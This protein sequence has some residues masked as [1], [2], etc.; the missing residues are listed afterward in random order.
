M[1]TETHTV[2][3][4]YPGHAAENDY[5]LIESALGGM[6]ATGQA[7]EEASVATVRLP[8][9][10]TDIDSDEHTVEAMRAVG[11]A[12][13]LAQG[14]RRAAAL[15]ADAVMWACTSGSFLYGWAGAH[16]QA[17]ALAQ[18]C[19][20]PASSTSLAFAAACAHLG[21][22][23]V[24]VVASYPPEVAAG[25][26]DFLG[27]AGITVAAWRSHHIETATEAG[28]LDGD[29][30]FAMVRAGVRPDAD[31]ILVPDTALHTAAWLA[32]LETDCGIP[33]LTANQVTVWQ[34]LRLAGVPIPSAPLGSL[35]T[36]VAVHS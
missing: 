25:F 29:Q 3:V 23:T 5:P 20:V 12:D 11:E 31:A 32:D 27:D 6:T 7:A 16:R 14:A 28:E 35:F 24:S 19:G 36:G 1:T 21:A 30:L 13:R 33:V 34:G 8:V 26:V 15:S 17:D 2:A 10:I 4:L 18:A 22:T 9:I